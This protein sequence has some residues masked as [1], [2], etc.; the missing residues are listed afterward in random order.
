MSGRAAFRPLGSQRC[1]WD[2]C[3]GLAL[4]NGAQ[5][6]TAYAALALYDAQQLIQLAETSAAMS[7]EALRGVTRAFHPAVHRLRPYP[8]AQRCA[9]NLLS[10][11]KGSELTDTIRKSKTLTLCAALHRSLGSARDA[12]R[13]V[14]AQLRGS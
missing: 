7:I 13:H 10:L 6:S 14:Q 2:P 9:R 1:S 4:T 3:E 11:M 12:L 8:G 5:L